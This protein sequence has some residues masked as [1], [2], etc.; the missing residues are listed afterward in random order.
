MSQGMI[1]T[2]TEVRCRH[3]RSKEMFIEVDPDP[4]APHNGSGIYWC[5]YTQHCLGPDGAAAEPEA[6]RPGRRC[7]EEL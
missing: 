4:R 1:E 3:L 5:V 7:Y 6:C 2:I